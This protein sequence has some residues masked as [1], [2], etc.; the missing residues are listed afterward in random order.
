MEGWKKEWK[1]GHAK[2]PISPNTRREERIERGKE[3]CINEWMKG[4]KADGHSI[5]FWIWT[6]G[7][8]KQ[9]E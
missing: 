3:G 9:K 6:G 2:K 7:I 4:W 5:L 1:E 8:L